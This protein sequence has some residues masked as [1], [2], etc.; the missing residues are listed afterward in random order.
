MAIYAFQQTLAFI[1]NNVYEEMIFTLLLALFSLSGHFIRYMCTIYCNPIQ[2]LCHN[3]Y[4]CDIVVKVYI[5]L[6]VC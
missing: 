6:Y 5:Q 2:Q 1:C 3:I 4:L